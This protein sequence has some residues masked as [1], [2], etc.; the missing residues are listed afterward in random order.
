MNRKKY[1]F[2]FL[3]EKNIDWLKTTANS[4]SSMEAKSMKTWFE[5]KSACYL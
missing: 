4:A 2:K 3:L 1:E 5:R